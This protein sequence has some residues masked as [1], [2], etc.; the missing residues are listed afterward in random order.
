MGRPN[1]S[2][3]ANHAYPRRTIESSISLRRPSGGTP[4]T[5]L[6]TSE[7]RQ[8]TELGDELSELTEHDASGCLLVAVI[9]DAVV[10]LITA[11][12]SPAPTGGLNHY[13]GPVVHVGD[14]TVTKSARRQGVGSRL[15]VA[16]EQWAR[17]RGAATVI[18]T[19]HAGNHAADALYAAQGYR[20]TD[21]AMRK[22]L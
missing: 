18:L 13:E 2:S 21:V 17:E 1:R 3:F 16:V 14:V 6:G 8:R 9:D 20:A 22:D 12:L 11:T 7:R 10:G 19:V 4:I 5:G 15:M